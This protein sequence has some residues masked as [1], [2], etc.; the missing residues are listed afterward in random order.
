MRKVAIPV[1]GDYLSEKFKDCTSYHII[2]I[3]IQEHASGKEEILPQ[4]FLSDL[5]KWDSQYGITDVITHQIDKDSI[6]YFSDTKINLFIG[7]HINTPDQLIE[8]Y[9]KGTLKSNTL[10]INTNNFEKKK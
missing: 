1:S 8:E 4:H 9:L 6:A 2:E 3:D 5:S 7:V 10:S